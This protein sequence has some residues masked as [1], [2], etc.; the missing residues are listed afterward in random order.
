MVRFNLRWSDLS[1][2]SRA[3][4]P[5]PTVWNVLTK[6][7]NVLWPCIH[8]LEEPACQHCSRII[9]RFMAWVRSISVVR[10]SDSSFSE[11]SIRSWLLVSWS[12]VLYKHNSDSPRTKDSFLCNPSRQGIIQPSELPGPS[13]LAVAELYSL[14]VINSESCESF[15]QSN[16]YGN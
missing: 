1:P 6:I 15:H 3:T 10:W 9:I 12:E 2:L 5:W 4:D 8:S 14:L 16:T 11:T 13:A 7:Y